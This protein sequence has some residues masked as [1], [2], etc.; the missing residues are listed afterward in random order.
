MKFHESLIKNDFKIILLKFVKFRGKMTCDK[1]LCP[2][3][4]ANK[5]PPEYNTMIDFFRKFLIDLIL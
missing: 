2:K 1:Y 5:K 3:Y 4:N